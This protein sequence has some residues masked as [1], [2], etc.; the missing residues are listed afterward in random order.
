MTYRIEITEAA[1]AEIDETYLYLLLRNPEAA[2]RWHDS[3]VRA[4]N[5]LESMPSRCAAAPEN[6]LFEGDIRHHF[7]S[8]GRA[9][10]RI[11]FRVLSNETPPVVRVLRVRHGARRPLHS[12]ADLPSGDE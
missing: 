4:I 9:A 6:E 2:A 11:I 8:F 1:E 12:A 5:S 10:Y 3:I 7:C